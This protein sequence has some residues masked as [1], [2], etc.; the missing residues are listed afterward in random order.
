MMEFHRQL[1][2]KRKLALRRGELLESQRGYVLKPEILKALL[3]GKLDI[4]S[5]SERDFDLDI[6]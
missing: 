5:I 3:L 2:K 4:S 1:V 6:V